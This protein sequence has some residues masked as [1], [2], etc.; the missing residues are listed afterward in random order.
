MPNAVVALMLHELKP[1]S[2][3]TLDDL[4]SVLHH[5]DKLYLEITKERSI[6]HPYLLANELPQNLSFKG[7][8]FTV[9]QSQAISGLIFENNQLPFQNMETAL[10]SALQQQNNCILILEMYTVAVI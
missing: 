1:A 5:G 3:W 4:D 9:V 6:S 8:D 10:E 7:S 2:T